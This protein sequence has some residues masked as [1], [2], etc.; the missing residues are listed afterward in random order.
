MSE[1]IYS[2]LSKCHTI[3]ESLLG[4]ER[5]SMWLTWPQILAKLNVIMTQLVHLQQ[6]VKLQLDQWI[7]SPRI[8]DNPETT[9]L[10]DQQNPFSKL[11]PYILLST[12]LI[13]EL[14]DQENNI[15]NLRDLQKQ[16]I[17]KKDHITWIQN[18]ITEYIHPWNNS[19]QG[20]LSQTEETNDEIIRKES[21]QKIQTKDIFTLEQ[22]IKWQFI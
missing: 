16:S 1:S 22:L 4:I 10:S 17:S 5:E 21:K 2:L 3:H 18:F 7:I 14:E 11:P 19:I 13:P 12:K 9:E 15:S 8:Q 20:I 6:D